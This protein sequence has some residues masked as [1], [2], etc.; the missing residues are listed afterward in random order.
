MFSIR[1]MRSDDVISVKALEREAS[2][3]PWSEDAYHAEVT[4]E[5]SVALVAESQGDIAGFIIGRAVPQGGG[6]LNLEIC[7]VAVSPK[8]RRKGIGAAMFAAAIDIVRP[9]QV[10]LEVRKSNVTAMNFYEKLGFRLLTIRK[11]FYSSPTEDA[12]T[13]SLSPDVT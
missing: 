4:S 2:I 7:N 3:S 12:L 11:D 5:D 8:A 1:R 6:S 10:L 9:G 13:L